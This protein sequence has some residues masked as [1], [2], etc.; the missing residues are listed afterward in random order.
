MFLSW[1]AFTVGC[2]D[3]WR[4]LPEGISAPQFAVNLIIAGGAIAIP[5][6]FAIAVNGMWKPKEDR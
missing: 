4:S 2:P 5:V 1:C 6:L 3:R